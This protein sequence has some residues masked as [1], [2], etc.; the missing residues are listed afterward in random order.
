MINLMARIGAV[1]NLL[2]EIR[3]T[4]TDIGF[5]KLFEKWSE[6]S[7]VSSQ[8]PLIGSEARVV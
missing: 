8:S 4:L 3:Q 1:Q 6:V 5:L 7:L 2:L